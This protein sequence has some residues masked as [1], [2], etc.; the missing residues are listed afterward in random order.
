MIFMAAS[1]VNV[2]SQVKC[3]H[4]KAG[5]SFPRG[6]IIVQ[7]GLN[8]S[9]RDTLQQNFKIIDWRKVAKGIRKISSNEKE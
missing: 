2:N 8:T 4:L 9:G 5:K 3:T 6:F 7:D 1:M